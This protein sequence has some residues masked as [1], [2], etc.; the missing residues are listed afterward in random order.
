[1]RLLASL[2]EF[3]GRSTLVAKLLSLARVVFI[4]M[5][6]FPSLVSILPGAKI[7]QHFGSGDVLFDFN[8][9]ERTQLCLLSTPID[10]ENEVTCKRKLKKNEVLRLDFNA[11]EQIRSRCT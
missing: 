1:M 2:W 7:F 8:D 9:F 4:S 5:L 10:E 6:L 3:G 11:F